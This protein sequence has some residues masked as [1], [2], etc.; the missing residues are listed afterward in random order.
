M[1]NINI[2][3][4]VV[5]AFVILQSCK[6][7]NASTSTG[8]GGNPVDTTGTTGTIIAGTDPAVASTQGFFL[9]GWSAKTWSVPSGTTAV[10]QPSATGAVA[11]TVDLSQITT[12]VS[13]YIFGNNLNPFMGQVVTEPI[14]MS[15]LINLS[16]N[17]LRAPGGSLSDVYFW[18]ADGSTV[19]APADAPSTLL[20][21]QGN[22]TAAY[23]WYGNNTAN[24]TLTLANYYSALKQSNSTGLITVNYGYARYGTSANPVAAAAHLA[25][26]WVRYDKGKTTY[27]EVG[28]EC[29]GNW[30]AG[31]RID[32]TKN[33][34]GQPQVI[35]GALYGTHFKVFADSM[36]A[37]AAQVGNTNI[38][39]GAVL[40]TIN[41][42]NNNAGVSNWNAGVLSAAANSPDFYVVHNYYTP[43]AQNSTASVILSSPGQ[44]TALMMS[45][46]KT[47][48][49]NAGL[50]QK[51]VAMD[52]WNI[53]A[54][55][56]A[57]NVSNIAGLHAVMTLGEVLKAQ[58]SMASRWDV[59]NAWSNGDD[60]GMFSNYYN[61]DIEPGASKW[62][63]RP[64]FYYM[65]YF[66]K[67]F[68]DRLVASTSGSS[69]IVSYGS[70]YTSGQAGVTLVNT[71]NTTHVVKVTFKN[72]AA[73]SN[74]YYY[75]LSGGTDNAP[76]SHKVYV[77]GNG[78]TTA[79]GGP[80]SYASIAANVSAVSGGI[81]VTIPAYSAVFLVT[82]KK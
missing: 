77:N 50:T 49:Q 53:E 72:F 62:N 12:K 56:S 81:T 80:S 54:T 57:Q 37:A 23:Y 32:V 46:V 48:I 7:D 27:W 55:G 44:Q 24:W 59:A 16:P 38:K 4:I 34:D 9:D 13:K 30:E 1:K 73:G 71:A 35:T 63:A 8:G 17:I 66:Q 79:S 14:L 40:T 15:Y 47:S 36:R 5:A 28:N 31:Y 2:T 51:P 10:T 68:G 52:E 25:A 18:N 60:Q 43:Y 61:S 21:Y 6:K 74:Y 42:Q 69:D 29:Y 3:I 26:E 78:P 39:I 41:D 45:W 22:S 76:F 20:D 75:I 33:K 58:I 19:T 82:D 70:S 64:A 65:Y 11:V 67:Y